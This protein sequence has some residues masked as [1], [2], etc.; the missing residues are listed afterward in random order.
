[1]RYGSDP[2]APHSQYRPEEVLPN[3]VPGTRREIPSMETNA[4]NK[5]IGY[6][7]APLRRYAATR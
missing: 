3:R 5:T 4:K 7:L 6:E 1:M 2:Q